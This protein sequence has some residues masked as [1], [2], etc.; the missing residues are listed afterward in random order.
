MKNRTKLKLVLTSKTFGCCFC[1]AGATL[2]Q[3]V[4]AIILLAFC[5]RNCSSVSNTSNR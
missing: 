1:G 5:L 2:R 4:R 3:S